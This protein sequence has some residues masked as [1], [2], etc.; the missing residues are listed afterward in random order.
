MTFDEVFI[1]QST[2]RFS[3]Q[4]VG[5]YASKSDAQAAAKTA[6]EM[7]CG[8]SAESSHVEQFGV[9][10]LLR[11]FG[12]AFR[13]YEDTAEAGRV[14]TLFYVERWLVKANPLKLLAEQAE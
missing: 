3:S 2:E 1:V 9:G 11:A 10:R 13:V 12:T 8:R 14:E 5:V 4:I 6:A 7:Y